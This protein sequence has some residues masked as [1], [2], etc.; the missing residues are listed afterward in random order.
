MEGFSHLTS[1]D[2]LKAPKVEPDDRA[3]DQAV[4]FLE[5]IL[6][7]GPVSVAKVKAEAAECG[8]SETTLQRAKRSLGVESKRVGFGNEGEYYSLL[9]NGG[10]DTETEA[11]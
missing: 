6:S 5:D 8:I 10:D 1:A 3:A 9:P 7:E 2:L 11:R 4:A